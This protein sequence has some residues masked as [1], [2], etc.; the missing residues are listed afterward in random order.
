LIQLADEDWV[1]H[2]RSA[3]S[4]M[5]F[6]IY[7]D[8]PSRILGT[9]QSFLCKQT[10]PHAELPSMTLPLATT[11]AVERFWKV[12]LDY[13]KQQLGGEPACTTALLP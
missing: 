7:S 1:I 3:S 4:L 6:P 2:D 11:M 5:V 10:L 13:W 12:R 9:L 8:K